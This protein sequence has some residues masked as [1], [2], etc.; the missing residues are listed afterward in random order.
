LENLKSTAEFI[1]TKLDGTNIVHILPYH[2]LGETKYLRMERK[3]TASFTLPSDRQLETARR[4][5][6]SAGLAAA[7]GG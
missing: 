3:I 4:I 2:P 1:A 6:E 5:F 7:I